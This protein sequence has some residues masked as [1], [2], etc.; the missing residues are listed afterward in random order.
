M[1][2]SCRMAQSRRGAGRPKEESAMQVDRSRPPVVPLHRPPSLSVGTLL[3]RPTS[4]RAE[5]HVNIIRLVWCWVCCM[6]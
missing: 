2:V 1:S 5:V 6:H 4:L 3:L